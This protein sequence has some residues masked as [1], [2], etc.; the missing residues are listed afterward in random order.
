VS[1]KNILLATVDYLDGGFAVNWHFRTLG[2]GTLN[3]R[4]A[5]RRLA[6]EV[7]STGLFVTS[8]GYS[9]S[10]LRSSSPEF[11]LNHR[12][13]L[14][15]KIPGF[16]WW[17]WKPEFIWNS[18]TSIPE[19]DGLLYLDAG[20]FIGR[21]AQSV[22]S[23]ASFMQ[24]ASSSGICASNSQPFVEK[25]YSSTQFMNHLNLAQSDRDS[26]QFW[27]GCLFLVNTESTRN[28]IQQ[29]RYLCCTNNHGFLLPNT[30]L[31]QE[32]SGFVHHMHDQAILSGLLKN[33]QVPIIDIG[34]R[35][36]P[37]AIRGLRHR[38]GYSFDEEKFSK[39]VGY[40]LVHFFSRIKL[41]LLRR[42]FRG[43]K[44]ARPFPHLMS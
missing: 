34:D 37:G 12:K 9:E 2:M 20:S 42:I 39:K 5:A 26:N 29:W 22:L 3:Y 27:A 13:V 19:G 43:P 21:D 41:Y 28:L 18:L 17:V 23:I 36:T 38:F 14:S 32:V 8:Q 1:L 31:A 7:A 15:A 24:I 44:F 40:Q 6:A 35:D 11:W 16:G 25:Y 33:V 10:F 30:N 4:V